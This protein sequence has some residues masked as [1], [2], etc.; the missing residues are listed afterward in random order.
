MYVTKNHHNFKVA[1]EILKSNPF[2]RDM[3]IKVVGGKEW[4]SKAAVIAMADG[5]IK[6]NLSTGSYLSVEDWA[7]AITHQYIIIKGSCLD[8][9]EV[10]QNVYEEDDEKICSACWEF[11]SHLC[12]DE[13]LKES[14]DIRE[15]LD[16][17][18][19]G[20][21]KMQ[22]TEQYVQLMNREMPKEKLSAV[23]CY[24]RYFAWE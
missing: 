12:T 9:E 23:V 18:K 17:A 21:L 3:K 7:Y 19:W 2:Y 8:S 4:E 6:A 13:C 10:L 20:V 14:A 11:A 16:Y 22:I 1:Y 24:N 5:Y 15:V